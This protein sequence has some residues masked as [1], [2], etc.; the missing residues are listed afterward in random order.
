[1]NITN[2]HNLPKGIFN[3][4]VNDTYDGPSLGSEKLS[5]TTLINP[6]RI[7]FLKKRHWAKLTEDAGDS[8]WRLLGS[9]VHAV[10][11][12][13][14]SKNN[15]VEERLEKTVDGVVISGKMDVMD[16]TMIEDYK[17]TSVWQFIHNQDGKKEHVAQLNILR[18]LAVDIFPKISKLAINLILRDWSAGKAKSTPGFPPIPFVSIEAPVWGDGQTIDYVRERVAL[19]KAAA[20]LPDD[21]LP[22]CSAEDVWE[23]PTIYAV[24]KDGGKRSTKN[25]AT[26]AEAQALVGPKMHVETR[27]GG[28]I[29]CAEYC[30]VSHL[31]NQY[32]D[33]LAANGGAVAAEGE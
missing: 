2:K 27:V 28:R 33:W 20:S 29:R 18:W 1:M 9:A 31:C 14:E 11:E 3:A 30:I 16:E 6:P 25:C 19:F 15:I 7:H 32:Q 23:R 22:E 12:R 26:L 17:I 4:I 21:K 8:L 13:A 10:L 5:V 24:M